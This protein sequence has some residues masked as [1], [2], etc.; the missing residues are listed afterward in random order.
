MTKITATPLKRLH[1]RTAA[2]KPDVIVLDLETAQ[3][4]HYYALPVAELDKLA[5][6]FTQQ[7]AKA[8]TA[9][10]AKVQ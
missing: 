9:N 2:E 10:G 3:G 6:L 5:E 4:S 8:R 7:A 1:I